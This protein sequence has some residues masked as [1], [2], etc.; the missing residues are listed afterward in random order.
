MGCGYYK[1]IKCMLHTKP[2]ITV[3]QTSKRLPLIGNA[4]NVWSFDELR[5]RANDLCPPYLSP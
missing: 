2:K 3:K 5:H 1:R 4:N